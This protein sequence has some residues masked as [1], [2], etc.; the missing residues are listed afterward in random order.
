MPLDT[1][2]MP[3]TSQQNLIEMSDFSGGW[4]PG[5]LNDAATGFMDT[6][7]P[8][9]TPDATNFVIDPASGVL[10]TRKGY[11]RLFTTPLTSADLNSDHVISQVHHFRGTNGYI[12][13]V[14]TDGSANADNVQLWVHKLS[15]DTQ[16]RIDDAG[17]TWDNPTELFYFVNVEGTLYGGLRGNGMFS[18]N[19]TD[20]YDSTASVGNYD[21]WVSTTGSVSSGQKGKHYAWTGREKV[22]YSGDTFTPNKNIRYESWDVDESY[23]VGDKVT[24]KTDSYAKSYKC[25]KRHAADDT[26]TRPDD[27]TT[28]GTYWSRVFLPAPQDSDGNTSDKWTLVPDAAESS[29]GVWFA[30]RMFLR[31][32]GYGD[33][34]RMQYSAP[35]KLEKGEDIPSTDWNPH[36]WAPGNDIR[37]QGGGWL[38]FTDGKYQGPI[39][40]AHSFGQYLVV[41]KRKSVW[42]LSGQDDTSWTVRRIGRGAGAIAS[43]SVIEHDGLLYFLADDGLHVTDGTAEKAADGNEKVS[44]WFRER[45]DTAEAQADDDGHFPELFK[46]RGLIGIAIPDASSDGTNSW[47]SAVTTVFYEPV[48]ASFWKTDLPVLSW[49]HLEL[50]EGTRSAVFCR[51]P[52]DDSDTPLRLIYEYDPDGVNGD[53]GGSDNYGSN[54]IF[55]WF[56]TAWLPFGTAREQRRIRRVWAAVQGAAHWTVQQFGDWDSTT[57]AANSGAAVRTV[58][59]SQS[60]Y[61]EGYVQ[62]DCHS[63]QLYLDVDAAPARLFGLSIDTQPRRKRYHSG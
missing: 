43:K 2:R 27:G 60:Q 53:D 38:P 20:G 21:A 9:V 16:V 6:Q 31:F 63:L 58:T 10:E 46:Y 57:A 30:D 22:T 25:I 40:A 14:V 36:D 35:V 3:M 4:A 18:W 5:E 15:D 12:V 24:R 8:T 56:Y 41:F 7:D 51:A 19:P 34:S 49:T 13:M 59:G 52:A 23:E 47:A 1:Q 62:A 45:L 42:V 29:I 33:R 17:V 39:T 48:T 26:V 32:D 55:A 11:K 44:T 28:W 54:A 37:G 50:Q 61:I